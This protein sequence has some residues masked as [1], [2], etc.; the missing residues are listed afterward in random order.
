[1]QLPDTWDQAKVLKFMKDLADMVTPVT[2]DFL[3]KHLAELP[4]TIAD[5]VVY[6]PTLR[7]NRGKQRSALGMLV[8]MTLS[9]YRGGPIPTSL[10]WVLAFIE[11]SAEATY[12]LDDIIDNQPRREGVKATHVQFGVNDAWMAGSRQWTLSLL[13]LEQI[14][15]PEAQKY[16]LLSL[17]NHMWD[18]MWEGEA[19]NEHMRLNS[20]TNYYL[21]RCYQVCA[22]MYE[23]VAHMAAI[24]AGADDA[25]IKKAQSVG[26]H[27]GMSA[28][29]GNDLLGGFHSGLGGISRAQNRQSYEDIRKGI[30][31]YPT[32]TAYASATP[33]QRAQLES[34]LGNPDVTEEQ[35]DGF[36]QLVADLGGISKTLDLNSHYATKFQEE[37]TRLPDCQARA[38][39]VAIGN[40]LEHV[41][42]YF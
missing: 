24:V 8:W 31:T 2:T 39:L 9:D 35:L 29:I 25:M 18:I 23:A 38:G 30:A 32:L 28:M 12:V 6:L 27:F 42:D 41:R 11:L 33:E 36:V 17:A 7:A 16:E 3:S 15:L 22:I 19:R 20:T 37:I 40:N 13:I 21:E 10:L 5:P 1:M 26:R 4:P 14:D 34:T